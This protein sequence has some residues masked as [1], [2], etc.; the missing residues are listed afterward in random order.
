[1][2]IGGYQ[3]EHTHMMVGGFE[4]EEKTWETT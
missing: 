3:R 4:Q 2:Q 1:M